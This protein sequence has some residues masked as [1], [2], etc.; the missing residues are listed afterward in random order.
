V[1]CA[2]VLGQRMRARAMGYRAGIASCEDA[3]AALAAATA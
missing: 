1:H 2:E 3:Q